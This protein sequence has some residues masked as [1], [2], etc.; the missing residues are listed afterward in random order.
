M[1]T[2]LIRRQFSSLSTTNLSSS[3]LTR[4][5]QHCSNS[6]ALAQAKQTHLQIIQSALHQNPFVITKLVQ[7][8]AECNHWGYAQKLFDELPEPNV[9]AWTSLLAFHSRNGLFIQCLQ[10]YGVMRFKGVLP[11]QYIFPKILRSCAQL[12]EIKTGAMIHKEVIVYGVELN[13]QV[14]NGLIDMYSKCGEVESANRV[15]DNMAVRD[16]LS[17]NAMISGYA[18]NGFLEL[19]LELF[20]SMKLMS[21]EP[22]L[23]TLNT[24]MDA[25]CRIGLCD[26][27]LKLFG[28]ILQPSVV[29]WTTLISGYSRVGNHVASMGMFRNM[30][31]FM[32]DKPDLDALSSAMVSCR[33]LRALRNGQEIH[34]YGMKTHSHSHLQFYN[35][36]GPA[37]LTMYSNC[38]RVHDMRTVFELMDKLDVVTWNAMILGLVDLEMGFSA[39]E[40]FSLMHMVGVKNDQTTIT[41]ILPVCDLNSGKQ[42]HAYILRNNLEVLVPVLNALICMYC[43][44][45][46]VSSAH[47]IFSN[48][49]W[50][51]LV[52]Y[53]TMIGGFAMHGKGDSALQILKE[54]ISSGYSPNSVTLTSILSACN[55]SGLIKEG[56]EV[57]YTMIRDFGLVP[58][59]DHFACLV[60]MLARAGQLNEAIDVAAKMP[61]VPD[62]HIWGTLLAAGQVQQNLEVAKL[63]AEKLVSLEPENAGHYVTLSN[64]YTDDGRWDDAMRVRRLMESRGLMKLKGSSWIEGGN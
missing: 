37:L 31:K 14:C 38:S 36:C 1:R 12:S 53:N 6:R 8:Y 46:S 52:S 11:D 30:V 2:W 56:V 16:L 23:V 5:L 9:F 28:K 50:K 60:D 49:T 15:F 47:L 62:K 27:A 17:W 13:L 54:M 10:L 3:Q 48:M 57:Y 63:A 25:Y 20:G 58:K 21:I 29:S 18:A 43:K 59:M 64:I 19:A 34:A 51:D 35:S 22:D 33:Y 55:H 44:R 7:S 61:I 42:V 4:L 39:L 32:V 24:V 26:E 45:G 41:T 40:T